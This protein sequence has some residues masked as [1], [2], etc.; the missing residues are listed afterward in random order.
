M[1]M[2]ADRIRWPAR[3]IC[4]L[5]GGVLVVSGM[6]AVGVSGDNQQA[7]QAWPLG[8]ALSATPT[9]AVAG[10][11][12]GEHSWSAAGSTRRQPMGSMPARLGYSGQALLQMNLCLSGMAGCFENT[13]YPRVV[14]EATGVI[15]ARRPFA[16]TFNEACRG[17]IARIAKETGYHLRFATVTHDGQ[18][19]RCVNPAG[20]GAFGNAVITQ[21][22][23]AGS[24]DG[25]FIAQ[26]GSEDRGWICV[27]TIRKVS[28]CTTHLSTRDSRAAAD[29]NDAQCKELT[30]VLAAREEHAAVLAAG[31]INRRHDCAPD[32][33]WARTDLEASKLPGLQHSYGSAQSFP[34]PQAKILPATYTDHDF[35]LTKPAT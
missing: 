30:A 29:A 35:L 3:V 32:S 26:A 19:L 2:T 31:D 27:T 10:T 12:T 20:R 7:A 23:V 6:G 24:T 14:E 13:Q 5:V 4:A 18:P 17:D 22:A 15:A 16:V 8:A 25:T 9:Q 34:A 21:A 28:V 33:M 1:R 11:P